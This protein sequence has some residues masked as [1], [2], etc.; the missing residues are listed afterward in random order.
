MVVRLCSKTKLS[1][2]C[3]SGNLSAE[4]HVNE[5]AASYNFLGVEPERLETPNSLAKPDSPHTP[6]LFGFLME[7]AF[8]GREDQGIDG[9]AR[10]I[11][12]QVEKI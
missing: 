6:L 12:V 9:I 11:T 4:A 3:L 7:F 2:A 5:L 10:L 1:L 8:D